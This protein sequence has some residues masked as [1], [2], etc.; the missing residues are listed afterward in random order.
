MIFR[1][2]RTYLL[3][4]VLFIPASSFA[5]YKIR[6][7]KHKEDNDLL[8]PI[9][10]G[11]N[12]AAAKRINDHL[13]MD[14]FETTTA[15]IPESKLFD[16]SRF[17][18]DDSIS[19]TG[20]TLI[21]FEIELNT[22]KVLSISFQVEGMGAYPTSF[23]KYFSF[24]ARSGMR[25]TADSLFTQKG[26]YEVKNILIQRRSKDI[27]A[28]IR[29]LKES[30]ESTFNEDSSFIA[31]TFENCNAEAHE[32]NIFIGK[33]N[34]LFYKGDC[35]PHAAMPYETSLDIAFTFKELEKYVSAYGKRILFTK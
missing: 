20:Y 13:Q 32:N 33:E 25:L 11:E 29:D 4:L 5:Q 8:F 22:P 28:W 34:V 12:N 19:Q 6:T 16:G 18:Q 23:E 1:R 35:F 30:N 26:V 9:L 31:E 15:K 24:D 14:F 3:F 27:K 21:S 2:Q 10:T 7:L 17:I